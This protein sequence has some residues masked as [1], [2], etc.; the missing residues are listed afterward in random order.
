MEESG[1]KIDLHVHSKCSTRPSQWILQKLNL[2][3]DNNKAKAYQ[4]RQVR[5]VILKYRL[6]GELTDA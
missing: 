2:Q 4:V 6:G 3:K 1:L 5:A